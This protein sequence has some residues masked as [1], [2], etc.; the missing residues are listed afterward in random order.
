MEKCITDAYCI[1]HTNINPAENK[2]LSHL[3]LTKL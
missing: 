2:K 3:S 1:P